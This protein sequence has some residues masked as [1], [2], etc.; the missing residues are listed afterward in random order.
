MT[1]Q[2]ISSGRPFEE[3]YGYSRAVR[4]GGQVHVSGTTAQGEDAY[5]QAKAIFEII[6]TALA[7]AGSSF[8]DVVRTVT[9]VT[10]IKD[11]DQVAKAHHEVL[12]QV[13]PAATLVQVTALVSPELKVEIEAYAVDP[14]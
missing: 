3:V 1:R 9:Y 8:E 7:E 11:A 5:T 2:N 13:K 6:G 4:V 12:G 10:D 14:A